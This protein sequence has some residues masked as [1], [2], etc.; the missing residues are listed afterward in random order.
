MYVQCILPAHMRCIFYTHAT[1][2]RK[3]TCPVILIYKVVEI[4][5]VS[6][7]FRLVNSFKKNECVKHSNTARPMGGA[8]EWGPGAGASSLVG[9]R[10]RAIQILYIYVYTVL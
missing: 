4:G 2:V 1:V 5:C 10:D 9:V 3:Q 8:L 7:Y 6:Q